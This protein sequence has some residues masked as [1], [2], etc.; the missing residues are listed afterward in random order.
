[1]AKLRLLYAKQRVL[2]KIEN[3]SKFK[4]VSDS[5]TWFTAIALESMAG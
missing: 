4:K 1:M 5:A 2:F 3:L